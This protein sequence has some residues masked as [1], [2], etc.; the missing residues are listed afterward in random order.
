M[1]A[2]PALGMREED[3]PTTAEGIAA[4]L[5]RMDWR[6][7]VGL[8]PQEQAGWRAAL[9]ADKELEIANFDKW[10]AEIESRVP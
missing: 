1:T 3:W 4:L 8:T 6:E 2:A 10:A 9:Q 5:A 7:P